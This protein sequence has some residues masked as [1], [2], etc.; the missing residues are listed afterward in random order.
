MFSNFLRPLDWPNTKHLTAP[1]EW[2]EETFT[3]VV[4][5][6]SR[7]FWHKVW[8]FCCM[9]LCRVWIRPV[10]LQNKKNYSRARVQAFC[11]F[12]DAAGRRKVSYMW[13]GVSSQVGKWIVEE[14]LLGGSRTNGILRKDLARLTAR[15][16]S[17]YWWCL[18]GWHKIVPC[19]MFLNKMN[20]TPPQL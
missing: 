12:G 7:P 20:A 13:P 18:L 19:N 15:E 3:A 6:Q 8:P 1:V 5:Q 14:F 4:D 17:F 2:S 16:V 9:A 11:D 10:L